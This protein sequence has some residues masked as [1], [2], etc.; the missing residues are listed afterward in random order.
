M[1]ASEN[2]VKVT[3]SEC[4]SNGQPLETVT[5][6]GQTR[7]ATVDYSVAMAQAVYMLTSHGNVGV[8]VRELS[9]KKVVLF[10]EY[11]LS[12]HFGIPDQPRPEPLDYIEG[13]DAVP[14]SELPCYSWLYTFELADGCTLGGMNMLAEV[15]FAQAVVYRGLCSPQVAD[16]VAVSVAENLRHENDNLRAALQYYGTCNAWRGRELVSDYAEDVLRGDPY[17]IASDALRGRKVETLP[18]AVARVAR[19]NRK[20]AALPGARYA[21]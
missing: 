17:R 5:P 14:D 12:H 7:A 19:W 16:Q 3:I 6:V 18:E 15:V 10:Y 13:V 21:V 9:E 1:T 11:D 2:T 4:R 8:E 20:Q